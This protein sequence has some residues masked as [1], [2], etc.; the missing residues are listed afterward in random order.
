[1]K[2]ILGDWIYV[3]DADKLIIRARAFLDRPTW[4]EINEAVKA[5]GGQW[6]SEGERSRWEAGA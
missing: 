3:K 2:N 6:V 4:T 1:L 5:A